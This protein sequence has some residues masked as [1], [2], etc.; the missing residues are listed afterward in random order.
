VSERNNVLMRAEMKYCI[1]GGRISEERNGA[2]RRG[3]QKTGNRLRRTQFTAL[4]K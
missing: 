1:S 4:T 2:G 3:L